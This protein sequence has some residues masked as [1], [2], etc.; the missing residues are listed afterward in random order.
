MS[1]DSQ[2]RSYPE[3]MQVLGLDLIEIVL[4]AVDSGS[5]YYNGTRFFP[6]KT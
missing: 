5:H 2:F 6:E 4:W 3:I 1:L